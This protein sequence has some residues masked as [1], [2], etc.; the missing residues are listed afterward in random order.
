MDKKDI[1]DFFDSR[2]A[3]WDAEQEKND[4]IIKL[5]LDN[6]GLGADMDV[7]DVACGTGLMFEYYLKRG[8]ASVTG[9]DLSPEMAK[10]AA[11]KFEHESR[12]KV[13]C[14]DVEETEFAKK[15]DRIV[16][17]NAF[18]HFPAPKR[19]IERLASLLKPG[20]CLTVAHG[21]SRETI[22]RHHEGP[23]S[24]VSLGLMEA[25]EL[26]K[27][28]EMQLRVDVCISDERMYQVCGSK[29]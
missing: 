17:Y 15:F 29:V 24:K 21:A 2:A 11:Q 23:A 19:L 10:I 5:I 6:A 4:E 1:I 25:E 28:F 7:L 18:P 3:T 27:I 12:I 13:I 8:A 22:D 20:G 14:G 26:K 16:V 9:I